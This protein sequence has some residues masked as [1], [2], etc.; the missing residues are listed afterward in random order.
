M[1][2]HKLQYNH[3]QECFCTMVDGKVVQ[4]WLNPEKLPE[5]TNVAR[6]TSSWEVDGVTVIGTRNTNGTFSIDEII[7]DKG[8]VSNEYIVPKD[9][10]LGLAIEVNDV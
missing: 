6:R 1:T 8:I 4:A 10:V 7:N 2:D 9:S 3:N 5:A